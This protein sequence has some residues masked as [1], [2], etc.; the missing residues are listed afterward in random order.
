[1]S[2][3]RTTLLN[4]SHILQRQRDDLLLLVVVCELD[5][6][7]DG[8]LRRLLDLARH[9]ELV[10]DEVRLLEVED[11]VQLA[12]GTEVLVQHLDEPVDELQCEELVFLFAYERS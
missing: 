4:K 1:M 10:Q 12:H 6:L 8:L 9:D 2:S 5:L 7:E 11:D 3:S